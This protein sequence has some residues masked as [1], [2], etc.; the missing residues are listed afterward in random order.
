MKTKVI[1]AVAA[2]SIVTL[3]FSFVSTGKGNH[4]S[5]ESKTASNSPAGGFAEE[6]IAK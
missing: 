6:E 5:S 3:S 4:K 1:L 2:I